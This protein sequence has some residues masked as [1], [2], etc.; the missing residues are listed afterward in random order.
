MLKTIHCTLWNDTAG[1]D[2]PNK[3]VWLIKWPLG[4]SEGEHEMSTLQNPNNGGFAATMVWMGEVADHWM[5]YAIR[6]DIN[7]KTRPLGTIKKLTTMDGSCF[8]H[9]KGAEQTSL[10]FCR[11]CAALGLEDRETADRHGVQYTSGVRERMMRLKIGR[12]SCHR[13]WVS[14]VFLT[15]NHLYHLDRQP[16][17]IKKTGA[18]ITILS[19]IPWALQTGR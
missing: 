17:R 2:L 5:Q 14:W 10:R 15:G 4:Q 13:N 16:N 8:T 12:R 18:Y 11:D 6:S 1:Y 7:L 19:T 9:Q 3:R